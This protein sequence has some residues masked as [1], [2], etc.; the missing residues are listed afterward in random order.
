MEDYDVIKL[1][2]EMI[3]SQSLDSQVLV[4]MTGDGELIDTYPL[5]TPCNKLLL[6]HISKCNII[7]V[8]F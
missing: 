8:I 4:I 2:L 3:K 7:N 1:F 5:K 6:C